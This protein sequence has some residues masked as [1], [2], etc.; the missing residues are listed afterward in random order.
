MLQ[1]HSADRCSLL[2]PILT[3]DVYSVPS[4]NVALQGNSKLHNKPNTVLCTPWPTGY[5]FC[6]DVLELLGLV[7]KVVCVRLRNNLALIRLL[8]KVLV[9]LL[10]REE[11]GVF[12]G[13]EVQVGALHD[14]GRRLPAHKGIL[15]SVALLQDIP[16]HPPMVAVPGSRLSCRLRGFVDS[17]AGC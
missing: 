5:L 12:L 1:N 6:L 7:N 16:I 10:L 14:I 15:P 3:T 8:N 4:A 11:N 13:L 17:I 2:K 9:T